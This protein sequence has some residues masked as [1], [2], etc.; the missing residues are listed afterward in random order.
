MDDKRLR[1]LF[2]GVAGLWTVAALLGT[3]LVAGVA[4]AAPMAPALQQQVQALAEQA[5]ARSAT[6]ARVVVEVGELD[7]RL[8]LA[9]C[10]TVQPYLPAGARA[11]GRTR[12]GLRC[13]DGAVRWN[14][15]LPVTV[16]VMARGLVTAT[17]LPAG[18]LLAPGDLRDAEVDLAAG[19]TPVVTQAELAV[20]RTLARGLAA[21]DALQ[22][23][24]LRARQFFQAGDA[25]Q[26]VAVGRGFQVS[27]AAQALGAGLEGQSVKVRTDSGRILTGVAAGERRVEIAL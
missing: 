11:W 27:S 7:P 10:P 25:V 22:Q 9:P 15:F 16:K 23:G 1:T 21:G 24:D 19:P 8:R 3:V 12:V 26:L 6:G 20:G 5:G 17:A 13:M 4:M 18:T 2:I 14:V